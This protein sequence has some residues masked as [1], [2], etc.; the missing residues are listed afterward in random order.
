VHPARKVAARLRT[1]IETIMATESG[2]PLSITVS[3]GVATIPVGEC[4]DPD[5]LV[6][7]AD[8]V[9]YVAKKGGRNRVAVWTD[10]A[11]TADSQGC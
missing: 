8:Q 4:W 9:L 5:T 10:D 2:E 11:A 3:L 6:N 7:R 1:V